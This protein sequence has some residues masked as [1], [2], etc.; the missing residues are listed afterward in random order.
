M[1]CLDFKILAGYI[2]CNSREYTV[3]RMKCFSFHP[4][5]IAGGSPHCVNGKQGI[6]DILT[7]DE[8][9]NIS[10]GLRLFIIF[11]EEPAGLHLPHFGVM[12]AFCD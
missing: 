1:V 8:I 12:A 6:N 3:A 2:K 5:Y 11:R 9:K 7:P 10:S 4:G